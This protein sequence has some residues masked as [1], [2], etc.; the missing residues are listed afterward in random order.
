MSMIYSRDVPGDDPAAY[1]G[2]VEHVRDYLAAA[3]DP[4]DD[5]IG[6]F[7]VRIQTQPLADGRVRITGELDAKPVAPY[8]APG[9]NPD[10]EAE[11]GR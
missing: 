11:A 2:T 9:Y 6:E 10:A 5:P 3:A 8:L 1:D 4:G 7:R